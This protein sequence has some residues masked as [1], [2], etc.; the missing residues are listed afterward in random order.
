MGNI[1]IKIRW[2]LGLLVLLGLIVAGSYFIPRNII[3]KSSLPDF[4]PP[5]KEDAKDRGLKAAQKLANEYPKLIKRAFIQQQIEGTLKAKEENSW[6][7]EAGGQT[8]TL[9]NQSTNK[10]FLS[11]LPKVASKSSTPVIYPVEIK[12]EDL[13]VGDFISI[14][15]LI[16]W[17]TGQIIITGITVLPR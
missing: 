15:Q 9:L 7:I 6:T 2:L 11:K 16:D 3:N 5:P 12:P 17:Q 8:I 14:N 10:V 1:P 13:K 4:T